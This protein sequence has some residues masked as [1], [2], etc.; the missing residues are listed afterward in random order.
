M[1]HGSLCLRWFTF[2]VLYY[3]LYYINRCVLSGVLSILQ[4]SS[5]EDRLRLR[6]ASNVLHNVSCPVDVCREAVAWLLRRCHDDGQQ[7]EAAATVV[8]ECLSSPGVLLL[9]EEDSDLLVTLL[10]AAV[11]GYG[12]KHRQLFLNGLS[13]DAVMAAAAAA[14]KAVTASPD[15]RK[16]ALVFTRLCDVLSGTA[17]VRLGTGSAR[18]QSY[19][20]HLLVPSL[21]VSASRPDL[22][23]AGAAAFSTLALTDG[24]VPGRLMALAAGSEPAAPEAEQE[25]T[26]LLAALYNLS[27]TDAVIGAEMMA[28]LGSALLRGSQPLLAVALLA[29]RAGFL[30]PAPSSGE[31]Q[32]EEDGSAGAGAPLLAVPSLKP[33]TPPLPLETR[34]KLLSRLCVCVR[35][36]RLSLTASCKQVGNV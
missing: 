26:Q 35:D 16:T 14:A 17:V 20:R 8:A 30:P 13:V 28:L 29:S 15:D 36:L 31:S 22:T 5:K 12:A 21:R 7:D 11:S 1:V 2:G 32:P 3:L 33:E 10:S 4:D 23:S 6:V 25:V 9:L 34:L 19:L 24:D 27:A 18:R